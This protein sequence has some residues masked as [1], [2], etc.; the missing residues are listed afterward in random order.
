MAGGMYG[1]DVAQLRALGD[2]LDRFADDVERTMRTL[3][4]AVTSTAQW[5]GPDAATFRQDWSGS[6]QPRMTS[7]VLALRSGARSV[8][9]NA[10]Q[11]EQ[12]SAV[13]G[14]A[15]GNGGR[16]EGVQPA[17]S[18]VGRP[19]LE[20]GLRPWRLRDIVDEPFL[21]VTGGVPL[22]WGQVIGFIPG[23]GTFASGLVLGEN[24]AD[25]N[26]SGWDKAGA[27][28]GTLADSVG[29]ALRSTGNPVA[30]GAGVAISTWVDVFEAASEADFSSSGIGMVFD[31]IARDPWGSAV[32]ASE[33]VVGSLGDI[34]DN[35]TWW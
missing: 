16:H 24:L 7:A 8:R 25:P 35:F 15:S 6:H 9:A 4:M 32:A 12:T 33:A 17:P 31:E 30:Y 18:T 27:A 23:V 20:D 3:G 29:G 21:G 28:V 11:Q 19:P 14:G 10:D 13:D 1:A 5:Q 2:Q 26:L 34:A 22:T